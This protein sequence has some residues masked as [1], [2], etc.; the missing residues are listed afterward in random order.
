MFSM[1]AL[2]SKNIIW[3]LRSKLKIIALLKDKHHTLFSAR[4]KD[5]IIA[6][7]ILKI[8]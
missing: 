4:K 6:D 5:T 8:I 3:I 1:K 7:A 2:K